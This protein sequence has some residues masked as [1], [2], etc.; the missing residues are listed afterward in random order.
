[1]HG[2]SVGEDEND[3]TKEK[4][5]LHPYD[6]IFGKKVNNLILKNDHAIAKLSLYEFEE[7]KWPNEFPS[8]ICDIIEYLTEINIE[9][10]VGL[11]N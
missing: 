8:I 2:S 4:R 6:N 5:K 7:I 11:R 3:E 9:T 10:M 1:M